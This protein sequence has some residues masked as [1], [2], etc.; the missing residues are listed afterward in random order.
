MSSPSIAREDLLGGRAQYATAGITLYLV[1]I[2]NDKYHIWE[3]REFHP[4]AA[5]AAYRLHAVHRSILDPEEPVRLSLP[6]S[7]LLTA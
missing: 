4:D 6:I 3:I 1:V 5:A 7:D 2:L